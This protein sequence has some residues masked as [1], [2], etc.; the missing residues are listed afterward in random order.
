MLLGGS[1]T[2]KGG[3]WRTQLDH[4]S[5]LSV[6]LFASQLLGGKFPFFATSFGHDML[7]SP[8]TTDWHL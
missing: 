1:G 6:F 7:R 8:S 5:T 4:R 3:A 2:S